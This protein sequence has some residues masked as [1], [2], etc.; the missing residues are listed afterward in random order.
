MQ[1]REGRQVSGQISKW[2]SGVVLAD[3]RPEFRPKCF[4]TFAMLLPSTEISGNVRM[5]LKVL[6]AQP[7]GHFYCWHECNSTDISEISLFLCLWQIWLCVFYLGVFG[8]SRSR[9]AFF[10]NFF[11]KFNSSPRHFT[12][13]D[14]DQG[15][16]SWTYQECMISER[17]CSS[18]TCS[19]WSVQQLLPGHSRNTF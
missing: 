8:K 3:I 4:I 16:S 18:W 17:V 15:H 6:P 19:I 7:R 2:A 9:S 5:F 1:F 13:A 12:L 10:L 14:T 11:G